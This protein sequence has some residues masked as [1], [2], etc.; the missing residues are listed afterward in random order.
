[1]HA[2][3]PTLVVPFAYDQPD[4]AARMVR[5]GIARTIG[6]H[7]YTAR[8]AAR[9]IGILLSDSHYRANAER[10]AHVVK[11]ERGTANACNALENCLARQN[12]SLSPS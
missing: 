6:R 5:L 12:V 10:V 1:M 8:L 3:R 9:E 11:T 7:K 2:G 4:N